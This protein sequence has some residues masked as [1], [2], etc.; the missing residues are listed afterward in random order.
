MPGLSPSFMA[1]KILQPNLK[2]KLLQP[3]SVATLLLKHVL[4]LQPDLFFPQ[5]R[6]MY[7][8]PTTT[9][10][11]FINLCTTAIW[12]NI[13]VLAIFLKPSGNH[14]VLATFWETIW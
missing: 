14:N 7:Y 2:S 12:H 11:L 10:M 1:G 9:I 3:F 6:R 8:L 5:P 4:F 13:H